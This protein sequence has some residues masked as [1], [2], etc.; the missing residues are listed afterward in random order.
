MT[1]NVV[2]PYDPGWRGK[3]EA[4]RDL[5]RDVMAP[6]LAADIEHIGSTAIPGM[7]AKPV[8]DIIA[9]VSDLG[10]A[11]GAFEA[12]TA[13]SYQYRP[14][15]PEAHLFDKPRHAGWEGHTHH[16]H[17]TE[18]GT[19]LWQERLAFRDALREDP[20]LVVEYNAWKV[21][22]AA[23]ASGEG[24]AYNETKWP[25]VARVLLTKGLHLEVDAQRL[26]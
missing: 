5:L 22:H 13:L 17:L 1:F 6:W 9:P 7:A 18:P 15:R 4:E 10:E 24:S 2:V 3:F 11:R 21:R 8:I 26:I 25:F 12:L 16:L 20:A 14:H 23:Q 19:A